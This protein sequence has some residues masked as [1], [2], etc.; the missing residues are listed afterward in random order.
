MVTDPVTPGLG[1]GHT[2][3][4]E[5]SDHDS[6]EQ[7][8]KATFGC[9]GLRT[10]PNRP[11]MRYQ[12]TAT[13]TFALDTFEHSGSLDTSVEFPLTTL[14]IIRTSTGAPA[15]D[16]GTGTARY[17]TGDIF[18]PALP[19]QSYASHLSPCRLEMC[20]LDVA[21]LARV[22]AT[23]PGR[24]PQPLRLTSPEP[25]TPAAAAHWWDTRSY[26]AGTLHDNPAAATPLVLANAAQ[27][28]AV[29]TLAA[30]PNT[31]LSDPTIEDRHDATP[32]TL[33]RATAF[34]DEHATGDISVADIAAHTRV[35]IRTLHLAFRRHLD[36]TPMAYLRRVRL[37]HTHRALLA[38]DPATTTVTAVAAVTASPTTAVSP[39]PTARP[40]ASCPAAPCTTPDAPPGSTSDRLRQDALASSLGVRL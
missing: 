16:R 36:T 10:D 21:L 8:L 38:A 35:S 4:L 39:P 34:I 33:R 31:A 30:F 17:T 9:R 2:T 28:L 7:F 15:V 26:I 40:T 22:A 6:I 20:Q 27:L 5:L 14:L 37:D 13:A 11:L 18:A 19:G 3:T 23:A 32:T 12:R 24:R 29:A 1:A 25:T